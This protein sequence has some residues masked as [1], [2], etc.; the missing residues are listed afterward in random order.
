MSGG[1]YGYAYQQIEELADSIV[2]STPLRRAFRT[3]LHKVAR[4]CHD[5]EWVDSG[6]SGPGDED[7]AIQ[8]VLGKE[9][10]VLVLAEVL[11]DAKRATIELAEAI[12]KAGKG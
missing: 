3:H 11:A 6:D 4:A 2:A 7:R 9:S 10:A 5:I 1:S 8:T 12:E